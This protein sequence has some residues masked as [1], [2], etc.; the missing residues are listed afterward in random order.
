MRENE[1]I[2]P[3]IISG[4]NLCLRNM[5]VERNC[6]S[7]TVSLREENLREYSGPQKKIKYGELKLMKN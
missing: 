5:G 2:M 1:I 4:M 6:N 7:E 3:G